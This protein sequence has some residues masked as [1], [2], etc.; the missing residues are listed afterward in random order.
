MATASSDSGHPFRVLRRQLTLLPLVMVMFCAISG[1]AYGLEKSIK[2]SGPGMALLLILITPLI[3]SLPIAL[4]AAELSSAMPV[5][6]GYYAWVKKGLGPFWG[7]Q[8]GWWSWVDS[9]V[10]T[11][12]YPVLFV[13]YLSTTLEQNLGFHLLKDNPWAAWGVGLLVIWTFAWL[14]IRG[15]KAVGNW[16]T[17]FTLL[18]LAPFAVMSVI[19]AAKW[20]MHP[21]PIGSPFIRPETS[22]SGAFALGLY[23]IMWNYLGWEG[24]ST[25]NGEI[26]DAKRTFPRALALT[27][28]LV[29]LAYLLPVAAGLVAAP[30]SEWDESYFPIAAAKVGGAWLGLWI[31]ICGLVSAS[32]LFNANMLA[33]S[34]LPF[35]LA[36]DGYLPQGVRRL[37]PLFGTPW[38]GILLCAVIYSVFTL[39]AFSDLVVVDVIV[40]SAVLLL[41]LAALVSLRIKLPN[42]QR[43]FRVP[44]GGPGL[45]AV[46]LFPVVLVT[47][48]IVSR[49]H[50]EGVRA[51]YLSLGALVTGPVLYPFLRTF[52]KRNQPDVEIPVEMEGTGEALS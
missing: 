42:M 36:A 51:L 52:V 11:A 46:V 4:M 12:I 8:A 27:I 17:V 3:W 6:G 25:V 48:A 14:N 30:W 38:V 41:E 26:D 2:A 44:G 32:G 15:V 49:V 39:T 29:T 24:L 21:V 22:V 20:V 40:Y 1:G 19:G 31:G 34:R 16:S 23:I 35:V 43:P 5:E 18:I 50:E 28:P 33:N 10:D 7:F 13:G 37:H 47:L 9:F 45:I